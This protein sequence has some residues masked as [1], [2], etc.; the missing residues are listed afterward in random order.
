MNL[1]LDIINSLLLVAI[2]PAIVLV[3]VMYLVSRV[4]HRGAA[5]NHWILLIG[6]ISPVLLV[7][8]FITLPAWNL[9]ILPSSF[10]QLTKMTI[11]SGTRG[12]LENPN[13][14]TLLLLA[15]YFFGFFWIVSYLIVGVRSIAEK[16]HSSQLLDDADVQTAIKE[17]ANRYGVKR[18]VIV[19]VSTSISS[20]L[21]WGM[22]KPVILLP[23]KFRSW[24]HQRLQRI[25]AH[26]MAHIA[27]HDWLTKL[28]ANIVRAAFWFL[29]PV[30]LVAR[31]LE[32]YAELACDDLLITHYQCRAEYADD[33][34][35]LS[36]EFQHDFF[37]L[38]FI[39][40]S[41]LYQ[42][43]DAVLDGSRVREAP[44]R[45]SKFLMLLWAMVLL[46]PLSMM[47]PRANSFVD[48]TQDY[49]SLVVNDNMQT[50]SKEPTGNL[51]NSV[52]V[53][54]LSLEEIRENYFLT[55]RNPEPEELIVVGG[56]DMSDSEAKIEKNVLYGVDPA[57]PAKPVLSSVQVEGYL[58]LI[59]KT[60]RY[61][62]HALKNNI[63]GRV[64]VQFDI[65]ERGHVLRPRIVASE[66]AE[67][68]DSPVLN[69]IKQFTFTPLKVN[70]KA[71]ITKNVTETFVFKIE[72]T[73]D[74]PKVKPRLTTTALVRN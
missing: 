53:N 70:G 25:L 48:T 52:L 36:S 6:L 46:L 1:T 29:P 64:I 3:V 65:S 37:A 21:T 12:P 20:P 19:R 10:G 38:S 44:A 24:S 18:E 72:D 2:K 51:L 63:E 34:L 47:Y 71:I 57:E 66:P 17:I 45:S 56:I 59:I 23:E 35:L 39:K 9:D 41:E 27:R 60:P 14:L 15:S 22:S 42:R 61:P 49:Y 40:R 13:T 16:T 28:L 74:K 7:L 5:A 73:T 32:C 26:E 11:I 58:P 55:V 43:I 54:Y 4:N 50:K 8:L 69:A 31:K 68:F 62:A 67:I 33:L 30:W